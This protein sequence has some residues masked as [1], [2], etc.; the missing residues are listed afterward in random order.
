LEEDE[1][2]EEELEEIKAQMIDKDGDPREER[3]FKMWIN[4]LGIEGL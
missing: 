2:A 3:A 4:S 1:L